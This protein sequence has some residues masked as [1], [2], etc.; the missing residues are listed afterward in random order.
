MIINQLVN[1]IGSNNSVTS[2]NKEEDVQSLFAAELEKTQTVEV[3]KVD[4]VEESKKL[5]S[6]I[7]SMFRTGLPSSEL[8]SIEER[9]EEFKK[10]IKEE[11]PQEDE[12]TKMKE[13]LEQQ[14]AKLQKS[15]TG[16]ALKEVNKTGISSYDTLMQIQEE[17]K[18]SLAEANKLK[19]GTITKNT[20]VN[21]TEE[22]ELLNELKSKS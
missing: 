12:L 3:P 9:T 18:S 2:T 15:D 6:D 13:E 7:L 11:K 21:N 14:M 10:R 17:I 5:L 16:E 22:F 1:A 4:D 20:R 19:I 8:E